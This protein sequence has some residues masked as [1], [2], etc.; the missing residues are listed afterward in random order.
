MGFFKAL[1]NSMRKPQRDGYPDT[2]A[3]LT[4]ESDDCPIREPHKPGTYL[5]DDMAEQPKN[6]IWGHSNPPPYLW[7]TL[8]KY[9]KG[10]ATPADIRAITV[11]QEL[12]AGVDDEKRPPT[13]S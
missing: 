6:S 12:H 11:F 8:R 4:C 3:L 1:S 10:K 9:S 13:K 2:S 7:D 5:H